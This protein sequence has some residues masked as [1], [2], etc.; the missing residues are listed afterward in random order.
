MK[1]EKIVQVRMRDQ[2]LNQI[3]SL[4]NMIGAPS[5]S[6]AIRRAVEMSESMSKAAKSGDRIVTGKLSI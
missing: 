6:D 3:E 1:N 2:T 4:Q 5:R